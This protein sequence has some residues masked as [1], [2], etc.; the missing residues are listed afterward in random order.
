M[1]EQKCTFYVNLNIKQKQKA[2]NLWVTVYCL[3]GWLDGWVGREKEREREG[4][5]DGWMDR[6]IGDQ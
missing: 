1:K 3:N 2:P 5:K 4:G 6:Q